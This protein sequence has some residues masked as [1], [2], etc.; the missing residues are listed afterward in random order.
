MP[1]TGTGF[2]AWIAAMGRS[3]KSLEIIVV[4]RISRSDGLGNFSSCAI[5]F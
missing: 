4:S 3:Y 5:R 1:A 2:G